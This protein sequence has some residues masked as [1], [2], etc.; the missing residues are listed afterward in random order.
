MPELTP[1]WISIQ[2]AVISTIIVTVLGI[3]I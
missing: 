1:F 3:F 2:V